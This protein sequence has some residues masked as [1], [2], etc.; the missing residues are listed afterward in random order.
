[1]SYMKK[2]HGKKSKKLKLVT[3]R[4][5]QNDQQK[6]AKAKTKRNRKYTNI[7]NRS[8]CD[9]LL[10]LSRES[11][12]LF[13]CNNSIESIIGYFTFLKNKHTT[14]IAKEIKHNRQSIRKHITN[15]D[16]IVPVPESG[17]TFAY[18]VSE[19]LGIPIHEINEKT[20]WLFSNCNLDI[21]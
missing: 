6:E 16:F 1:M 15:I 17:R 3:T 20:I 2:I 13:I 18:G 9:H 8:Y 5:R 11:L 4:K 12:I 10:I 14:D 19:E 7:K 21:I